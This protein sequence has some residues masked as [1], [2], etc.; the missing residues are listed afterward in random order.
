MF[1]TFKTTRLLAFAFLLA[2]AAVAAH[3]A[4]F[5]FIAET[6]RSTSALAN[7]VDL[8]TQKESK[9][10]SIQSTIKDTAADREHLSSFLVPAEGIV[11]FIEA[12]EAFG[13]M[14]GAAIDVESVSVGAIDPSTAAD[15]D[16]ALAELV[17]LSFTADGT[18]Q[19]VV[20]T[21]ALVETLPYRVTLTRATL[22]AGNTP[23]EGPTSWSGAF[24]ITAVKKK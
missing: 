5:V 21:L 11:P 13:V 14:T 6:N 9:L 3:I 17:R 15:A 18:W 7:D 20:H 22:R 16:E 2:L 19:E 8:I 24:T 10:R 12:I 1:R 23:E 4:F